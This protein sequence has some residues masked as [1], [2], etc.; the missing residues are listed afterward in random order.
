MTTGITMPASFFGGGIEFLAE[1]HDVDA[2]LT[3]RGTDRAARD[4]P[5]RPGIC[6]LIC[7]VTFFA[8]KF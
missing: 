4:W 1:R 5:A 2:V 8:I 3:Q 6:N 7:P